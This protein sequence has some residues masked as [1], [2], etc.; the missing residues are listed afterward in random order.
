MDSL[1]TLFRTTVDPA[2]FDRAVWS[3]IFNHRRDHSRVP[4]AVCHPRS[5]PDVVAAVKLA[6][7]HDKRISIRSGGHSWAAWSVRHDAVLIDLVGL[8]GMGIAYDDETGV[9]SV[10]PATTGRELNDFL[11][12][13]GRM[14][15]GGHCP[16]V[17]MGGFLLQGG[18]GWNAKVSCCS[19]CVV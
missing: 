17:G 1:L 16:D 3:R 5:I 8:N 15:A 6:K 4:F 10:P 9:G 19:C 14:F 18:M 13:H 7:T 2:R 12:G 11:A